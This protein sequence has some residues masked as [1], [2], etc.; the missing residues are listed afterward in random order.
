MSDAKVEHFYRMATC[1]DDLNDA[2]MFVM[3]SLD[4]LGDDPQIGISPIWSYHENDA[5]TRKFEV[6]CAGTPAHIPTS[7]PTLNPPT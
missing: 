3:E 7:H 4:Q 5:P 6:W 1:V 2:F